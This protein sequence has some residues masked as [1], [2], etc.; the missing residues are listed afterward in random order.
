MIAAYFEDEIESC[1]TLCDNCTKGEV[2][3]VD[4]SVDA[5]KLLSA[6]YRSEQRFGLNHIIDI[7]R[8]SKNQKL[9]DFG[10]D[11]LSVYNLGADKS[12]NEWIAIADKLIDIQALTLGEFRALKISSLGLEILKGKEKLF[13]D[14]DKLGIASKIQEEETELSFD[15]LIYERFRT[16][17]REIAQES[18]VPAYVI[19]GD[20]TLKE[21][22]L[23]L[24]ITKDE[25]LNINGVGL[26][27][28]E[29]Y[30]ETF[31][32]LSKEIK[33]EFCEKLE[34]KEPLKKLTKTYL[35][36]YELLNEG[37]SVEEIA[38]IRDLGLTSVLSHISVLAEHEKISKEKKEELLKPLEIP[39]N[40]KA[41]I[42][43]GTKLES[44]KELRQYLY[45]YEYLSKQ[46]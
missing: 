38:Q 36:T 10:H 8:G 31:L 11:K 32:N 3:Q 16:L 12:K 24:P 39:S 37:K 44:L 46:D 42:E 13:I 23:K 14:S 15:E 40:I 1:K 21:F 33:E 34:Q 41:W 6:I 9:L 43:E 18:E 22:A 17:R 29:K 28:Y 45:L 27:K 2:E 35:E 7:L 4:M 25:M 5:Q 30:G 19:F 20:K 26:V